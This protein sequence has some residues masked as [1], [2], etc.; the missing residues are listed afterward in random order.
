MTVSF[1]L[2]PEHAATYSDT[3]EKSVT[4][5]CMFSFL[6][7]R[8]PSTSIHT[9][10]FCSHVLLL[11]VTT[12]IL[13]MLC[14]WYVCACATPRSIV[15]HVTV[16]FTVALRTRIYHTCICTEVNASPNGQAGA[17]RARPASCERCCAIEVMYTH[18]GRLFLRISFSSLNILL[19]PRTAANL[20]YSFTPFRTAPC[21]SHKLLGTRV[22]CVLL[23]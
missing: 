9:R 21:F 23:L 16:H 15:V 2:P 7:V 14:T 1:S 13:C 12:R 10:R 22:E 5:L 20:N 8:V 11:D 3:Q 6:R 17:A 18:D 4:A 19:K